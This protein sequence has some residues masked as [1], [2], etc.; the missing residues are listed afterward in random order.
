M[1]GNKWEISWTGKSMCSMVDGGKGNLLEGK[2]SHSMV[3]RGERTDF[4]K[5]S[6][7]APVCQTDCRV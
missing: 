5:Y 3:N 7:E 4:D 2:S 6:V 1:E